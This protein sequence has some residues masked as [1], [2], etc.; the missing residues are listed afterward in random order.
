MGK[1]KAPSRK[2]TLERLAAKQGWYDGNQGLPRNTPT[3]LV[4]RPGGGTMRNP[5]PDGEADAYVNGYYQ[6][7]DAG[8]DERN[9]YGP[10]PAP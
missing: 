8:P 4:M 1:V 9:P 5:V 2:A 10:K 6:G 7:Q 3:K